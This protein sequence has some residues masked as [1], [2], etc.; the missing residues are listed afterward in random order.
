[1][2]REGVPSE[3]VKGMWGGSGGGWEVAKFTEGN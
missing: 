1:M 2:G 3:S